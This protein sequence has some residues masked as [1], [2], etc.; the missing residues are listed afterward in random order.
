VA[1]RPARARNATTSQPPGLP[2]RHVRSR[3]YRRACAVGRAR[4][5]GTTALCL[6]IGIVGATLSACSETTK[7]RVLSF[8]LD[9]VPTPGSLREPSVTGDEAASGAISSG[10]VPSAVPPP[11][12]HFT[13]QPYAEGRCGGCHDSA[14]GQLLRPIQDGLCL[15]C[16]ADVAKGRHVHGPVAVNGCD[17]CHLHHTAPYPNLLQRDPTAT[18]LNCHEREDLAE[19]AQHELMD[20]QSCTDCHD[21]HHGDARYFLKR[22]GP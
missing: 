2:N 16:H 22:G 12:R 14:S 3:S 17:L 9:G 13:H 1:G 18:C 5:R 4:R 8:F 10:K 15:T 20:R 19:V 7:Y 21:P 6:A 11:Q